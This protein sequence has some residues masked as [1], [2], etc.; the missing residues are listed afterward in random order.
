MAKTSSA[1]KAQ[2]G[3]LRRRVFNARR[4]KAV[5]DV[6][7]EMSKLIATKDAKASAAKLSTL[8]K[9]IDKAAKN[10]TMKKNTAARMKSRIAKRVSAL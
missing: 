9:A 8:F 2:R 4:K 10:G 6:V 3:A 5:K 1:K 7:K